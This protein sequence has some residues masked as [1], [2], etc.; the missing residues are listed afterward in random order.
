M[1]IE[2]IDEDGSTRLVQTEIHTETHLVVPTSK[3]HLIEAIAQLAMHPEETQIELKSCE[4]YGW[5]LRTDTVRCDADADKVAISTGQASF[6]IPWRH[7]FGLI[8]GAA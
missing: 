5:N 7:V 1:Q 3:Q 6:N 2:I 8:G 4:A